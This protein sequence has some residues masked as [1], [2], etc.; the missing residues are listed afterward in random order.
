[1]T[2][3][4]QIPESTQSELRRRHRATVMVVAAFFVLTLVLIAIAF[5]AMNKIARPGDQRLSLPLW[6]AI[7]F[8][9][10]GAFA[11]RRTKFAAMRLQ[12][13]AAL[14]GISGLLQTL[15]GTTIQ[16]AC[17]AG[18]ISLMGFVI[19]MRSVNEY[20]MLRAGGVAIIVLIYS[21]PFRSAW[22]RVVH[23][24]TRAGDAND[25]QSKGTTG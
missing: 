18:A 14:R 24:I 12:D 10:F 6:I 20:D 3:Q 15:Q 19:A 25:A 23:G 13:I 17:L 5:L 2:S 16:V 22:E 9:G 1:M 7:L 11:L 4:G 21:Y 8:F